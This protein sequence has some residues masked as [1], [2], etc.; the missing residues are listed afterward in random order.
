MGGINMQ[1]RLFL[2]IS[3]EICLDSLFPRFYEPIRGAAGVFF[4]HISII[5]RDI[6]RWFQ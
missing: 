4:V 1:M 5:S 2:N 6:R 3:I